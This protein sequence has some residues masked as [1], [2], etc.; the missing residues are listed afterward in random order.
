MYLFLRLGK[1]RQA[2]RKLV[3]DPFETPAGKP[4]VFSK[5]GRTIGTMHLKHLLLPPPMI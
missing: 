3:G 1:R 2:R 5:L 4:V